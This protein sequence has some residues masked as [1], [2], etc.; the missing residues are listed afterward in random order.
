MKRK[1]MEERQTKN[2][3]RD[4]E[5]TFLPQSLDKDGA[6]SHALK[7]GKCFARAWYKRGDRRKRTERCR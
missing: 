6:A 1:N 2:D 5:I 4:R 7:A 3:T